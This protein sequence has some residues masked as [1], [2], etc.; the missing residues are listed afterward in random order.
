[1]ARDHVGDG[2]IVAAAGD[3]RHLDAGLDLEVPGQMDLAIRLK[4]AYL[5]FVLL[6][7]DTCPPSQK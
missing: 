4:P 1:M 3:L 7:K 2:K 5:T 6:D